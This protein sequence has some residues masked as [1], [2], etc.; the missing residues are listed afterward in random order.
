MRNENDASKDR[1]PEHDGEVRA[2]GPENQRQVTKSRP[3][4]ARERSVEGTS[5]EAMLARCAP[6]TQ[7]IV[8]H[9]EPEPSEDGDFCVETFPIRFSEDP[10]EVADGSL[11]SASHPSPMFCGREPYPIDIHPYSRPRPALPSE[12]PIAEEPIRSSSRV[13]SLR[14][15]FFGVPTPSRGTPNWIDTVIAR[16]PAISNRFITS[17]LALSPMVGFRNSRT[18]QYWRQPVG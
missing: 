12:L 11:A 15:E 8:Q 4:I 17:T 14:I 6:S 2:A 9:E 1:K 18:L 7:T 3:S 5:L 13:L 16:P 10:I